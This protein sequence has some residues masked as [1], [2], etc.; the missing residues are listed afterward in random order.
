MQPTVRMKFWRGTLAPSACP[1]SPHH[2][3]EIQ[4]WWHMPVIPAFRKWRQED[5]EFRAP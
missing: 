4:A 5:Q 1:A 3:I 2:H